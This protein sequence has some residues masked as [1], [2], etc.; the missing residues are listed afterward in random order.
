[1]RLLSETVRPLYQVSPKSVYWRMEADVP[2]TPFTSL[3][4]RPAPSAGTTGLKSTVPTWCLPRTYI[5]LADSAKSA[6]RACSKP[7]AAWWE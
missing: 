4:R 7:T 1:M 2:A 6:P 5:P 3:G